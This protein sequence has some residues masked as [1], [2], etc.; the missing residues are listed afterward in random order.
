MVT[1]PPPQM[2][3]EFV[4]QAEEGEPQGVHSVGSQRGEAMDA[5]RVPRPT[6]VWPDDVAQHVGE[7]GVGF[8]DDSGLWLAKA[9]D[10]QRL[11]IS[12]PA[13]CCLSMKFTA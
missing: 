2:L 12:R 6:P 11:T 5:T 8:R 10:L 9:G 7:L 4:V 3:D 1:A 13:L